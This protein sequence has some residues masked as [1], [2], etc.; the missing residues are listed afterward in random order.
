MLKV[1]ISL[2]SAQICFVYLSA[3]EIIMTIMYS[4]EY[5]RELEH[6]SVEG[7]VSQNANNL[8]I[9]A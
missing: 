5:G 4:R 8:F 9:K 1:N 2:N 6:L 7:D 3:K